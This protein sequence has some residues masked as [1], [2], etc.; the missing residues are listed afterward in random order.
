MGPCLLVLAAGM[1]SRFGGL[2]QCAAYGPSDETLLEYSVYDAVRA[3]FQKIVFVIRRE[4]EDEFRAKVLQ[5]LPDRIDTEFIYQE[6]E[7][8]PKGFSVPAGRSKPWG[9][10]H[11]VFAARRSIQGPFAVINADDYYGPSSFVLIF[12]FLKQHSTVQR[13]SFGLVG[14]RLE[15]TLSPWGSVSRAVCEV[16]DTG[17]LKGMQEYLGIE[18]TR[19]GIVGKDA[20]GNLHRFSGK[21]TVAVNFFGFTSLLFE[22]LEARFRLFL[23]QQGTALSSE[24][25]LPSAV[26]DW[27]IRGCVTVTVL[28]SDE[29]WYGVTYPEEREAMR[30][31]IAQ[32]IT[33]GVY[34]GDLWGYQRKD[35]LG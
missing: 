23:D 10:A 28:R 34:P 5:R 4:F 13:S 31:Q 35:G 25:Y 2:K 17:M 16:G 30:Q 18:T 20:R 12:E 8:V 21:E 19:E 27:L 26:N 33:R 3:G 24:F 14:F 1:G 7:D 6:L 9:T 22:F 11:A 15:S 29:K 32:Q